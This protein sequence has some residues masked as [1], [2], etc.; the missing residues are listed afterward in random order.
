MQ[1]SLTAPQA[2]D[3]VAT[4]ISVKLIKAEVENALGG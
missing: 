3:F 1:L 2:T 4:S